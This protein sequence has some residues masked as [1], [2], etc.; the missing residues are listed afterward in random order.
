ML[1]DNID[2][3][4]T[5]F[6]NY[7]DV[8]INKIRNFVTLEGIKLYQPKNFTKTHNDDQGFI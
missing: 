5:S 7:A 2:L 3:F 6:E 1:V 8:S 4:T